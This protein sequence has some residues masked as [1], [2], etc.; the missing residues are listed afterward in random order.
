MLNQGIG[1]SGENQEFF[2][3]GRLD[4]LESR[5]NPDFKVRRIL[6]FGCGIG[7]ATRHLA[8]RFEEAEVVGVD[9]SADAL[10]HARQRYGSDRVRFLELEGLGSEGDFDL[11]YVNGVFHHIALTERRRAVA[12]IHRVLRY[13][14]RLALFENNPWNPGARLVMKRIPFDRE[15]KMLSLPGAMA[16]VRAGAFSGQVRVG[17]SFTFQRPLAFL[18]FSEGALSPAGRS[19]ILRPRHQVDRIESLAG[20]PPLTSRSP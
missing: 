14:G 16:L 5:L 6:D 2:I 19:A 7:T 3:R 9:T 18:R 13:G 11:C 1:L 20:H 17:P 12:T 4:S 15:A 8:D 10:R